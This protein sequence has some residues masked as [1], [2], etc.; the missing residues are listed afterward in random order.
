MVSTLQGDR[1][2]VR[3]GWTNNVIYGWAG[4][5]NGRSYTQGRKDITSAAECTMRK[6]RVVREEQRDETNEGSQQMEICGVIRTS[7]HG[8]VR[9][10]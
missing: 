1:E 10:A 6:Q 3:E 9:G 7:G 4:L 8:K 5:E 2:D